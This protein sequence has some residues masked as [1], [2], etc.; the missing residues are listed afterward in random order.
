MRETTAAASSRPARRLT[1]TPTT[2][3]AC[4]G[5]VADSARL[6]CCPGL[7]A[8]EGEADG[9]LFFICRTWTVSNLGF[10]TARHINQVY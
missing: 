5:D 9:E 10:G 6:S 7:A 2:K 3:L 1:T 4:V 8:T